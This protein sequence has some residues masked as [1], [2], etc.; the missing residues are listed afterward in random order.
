MGCTSLPDEQA[1]ATCFLSFVSRFT[2]LPFRRDTACTG[3][4][5][6]SGHL[7]SVGHYEQKLWGA[8]DLGLTRVVVPRADFDEPTVAK[9]RGMFE[10]SESALQ[11]VAADNVL[12]LINHC[13]EDGHGRWEGRGEGM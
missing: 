10:R 2:T 4:L 3:D 1:T 9:Y 11:V 12:E 5:S 6:L 8:R 7:L 13:V